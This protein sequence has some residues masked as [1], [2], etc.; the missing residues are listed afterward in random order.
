LFYNENNETQS[1]KSDSTAAATQNMQN[2]I[3]DLKKADAI[4]QLRECVINVV[5]NNYDT[6]YM[7]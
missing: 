4:T 1:A 3:R 2:T 5:A 6:M 7:V